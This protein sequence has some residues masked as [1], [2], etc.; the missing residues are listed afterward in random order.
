MSSLA[1]CFLIAKPTLTDS[2]FGRAVI[3]ILQQGSDGAFG[4]VL[5]RPTSNDEATVRLHLGGPCKFN[6]LIMLHGQEEWVEFEEKD[7]AQICPGVFLGDASC[8][9]RITDPPLDPD[10]RYKVFTGYSGWAPG[11]LERELA[12][13][14]WYV[15]PA[16]GSFVF[17]LPN[18]EMW[19]RLIPSSIPQPSLN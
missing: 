2:F 5:N 15:V 1:G 17:D 3:L 13:G 7:A 4:L 14:S 18:E 11:Q 16:Q 8:L 10:W 19:V 12:E 6:G 9:K